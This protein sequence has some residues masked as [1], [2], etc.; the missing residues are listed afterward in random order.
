MLG[1]NGVYTFPLLKA[2]GYVCMV[3]VGTCMFN[4]MECRYFYDFHASSTCFVKQN[5]LREH[6]FIHEL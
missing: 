3:T 6:I 4:P 5:T 2:Q 1:G